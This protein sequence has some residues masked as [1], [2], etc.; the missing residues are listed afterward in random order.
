MHVPVAADPTTRSSSS[1]DTRDVV[2]VDVA[3]VGGINLGLSRPRWQPG[4]RETRR[5]WT[6]P[7]VYGERPPWNYVQLAIRGPR[8]Y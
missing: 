6:F 8:C 7:S 4:T 1:S 3:F 2:S 5:R